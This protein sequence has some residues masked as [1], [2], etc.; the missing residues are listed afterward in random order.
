MADGVFNIAKGRVLELVNR[1]RAND[2]ANSALVLVVLEATGLVSDATMIDYDTLNDIIAGA[3]NE[4][5]TMG[6][7]TLTDS[8]LSGFAPSVIDASDWALVDIPDVTWAGATGNGTGKLI[9]CYDSDTTGGTDANIVPLT[10]HDFVE[11][12]T[13]SDIVAQINASGIYK[14]A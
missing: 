11:T 6:R 9:V 14:A 1:V 8:D 12:P 5:T 4:Q 2:P 7:K 3:S 13:G 10:Y